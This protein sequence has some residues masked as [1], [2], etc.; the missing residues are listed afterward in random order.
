MFILLLYQLNGGIRIGKFHF[1]FEYKLKGGVHF[2]GMS[3]IMGLYYMMNNL[4][5]KKV[6]TIEKVPILEG[7]PLPD[8]PF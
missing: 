7:H 1:T 5:P 6:S 3:I 8:V 2:S 4:G